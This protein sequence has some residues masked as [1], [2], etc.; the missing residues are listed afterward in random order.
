MM[1][2]GSHF[3]IRQ[4]KRP[5]VFSLVRAR[6]FQPIFIWQT[7]MIRKDEL[8]IVVSVCVT[9]LMKIVFNYLKYHLTSSLLCIFVPLCCAIYLRMSERGWCT[10]IESVVCVAA[11]T[12]HS[13][14]Y[15]FYNQKKG[16]P[17]GTAK[18]SSGIN[19][20]VLLFRLLSIK[21][22]ERIA[23]EHNIILHSSLLS[24]RHT[25]KIHLI[26]VLRIVWCVYIYMDFSLLLRSCSYPL[27]PSLALSTSHFFI[28][29]FFQFT[30]LVRHFYHYSNNWI[31]TMCKN[32]KIMERQQHSEKNNK[33]YHDDKIGIA[34]E[35]E[36]RIWKKK[37]EKCV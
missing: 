3:S 28:V 35:C 26:S 16:E 1:K 6:D 31:K 9:R 8:T 19:S 11:H 13:T 30:F 12:A 10:P 4:M 20:I 32:A 22:E 29:R 18:K 27:S 17:N 37:C 7:T 33:A 2:S 34:N 24:H 36:G 21:S 15:T 23:S 5:T 25:Q 14:T